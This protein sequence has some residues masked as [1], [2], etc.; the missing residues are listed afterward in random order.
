[1][2]VRIA[3]DKDFYAW[4]IENAQLLREHKF[5]E[6]DSENVAEEL[7]SMGK[8]EKRELVNRLTILLAHLLKWTFQSAKRSNSWKN[9]LLTQRIDIVE[10]LEDSPSLTYELEKKIAIAYEKAK[11]Q[12]ENETGITK[13]NFPEMCPFTLEKILDRDFFPSNAKDYF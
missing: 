1:M 13:E 2:A 9:T 4:L 11:L 3:Y 8:R 5:A 6:L 7:E 10:W 12:A